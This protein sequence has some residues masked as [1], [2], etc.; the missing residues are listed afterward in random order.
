M[1]RVQTTYRKR[2]RNNSRY[3]KRVKR[4]SYRPSPNMIVPT[5]NSSIARGYPRGPAPRTMRTVLRYSESLITVDG[6]AAGT[7]DAYVFSANGLFDP[8]ITGTGHQPRGFDQYMGLYTYYVVVASR[9]I[10]KYAAAPAETL[11]QMIGLAPIAIATENTDPK[12][13]M[14]QQG[15]V[16]DFLRPG[17][18]SASK[19]LKVEVDLKSWFGASSLMDD[20]LLRGDSG[21]NPS[22]QLYYHVW[23]SGVQ[24]V[25]PTAIDVNV[26]I[27]YDV[28]FFTPAEVGS[29]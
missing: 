20:D 17:V 14:E 21:Q 15:N 19:T 16:Y 8:N 5:R 2:V 25:N 13:Y 9:I 22:R 3:V 29:S 27:E 26:L 6:G 24:A 7:S 10:A 11:N 4:N 18:S 1:A 23:A 12:D 28:I